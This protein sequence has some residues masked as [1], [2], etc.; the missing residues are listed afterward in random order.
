MKAVV[1]L[2]LSAVC[3]TGC[4][5]KSHPCRVT[6]TPPALKPAPVVEAPKPAVVE[7]PAPVVEAPKPAPTPAPAPAPDYA[8]M[9][10]SNV[11]DVYFDFDKSN[12][13]SDAKTTLAADVAF[14]KA[15][16]NI[17]FSIVGSCDVVGTDA[18]NNALGQRRMETVASALRLAGIDASRMN[19]ASLGKTSS[20]CSA[21]SCQQLNRR[22]HFAYSGTK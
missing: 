13:R 9:F 4:A 5:V 20:Y 17:L 3:L 19:G 12:L 11:N 16:P 22:V 18:Y 15:N 21:K 2:L 1:A 6:P 10:K 8:G 7:T 14:L